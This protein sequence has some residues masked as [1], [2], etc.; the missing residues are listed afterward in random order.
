MVIERADRVLNLCEM[1]FCSDDFKVDADDDRDLRHKMAVFAEET[2]TRYSLHLTLVT[3]YGLA[4]S[5]YQSRFQNVITMDDQ[6]N[7]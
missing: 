7:D 2:Q 1:K 6:F 3:T 4:N 5:P